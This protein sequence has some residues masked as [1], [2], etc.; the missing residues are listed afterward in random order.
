MGD[1]PLLLGGDAQLGC[2]IVVET[3]PQQAEHLRRALARGAD[4]EN[5]IEAALVL[6]IRLDESGEGLRVRAARSGLLLLG[7]AAPLL[8]D[9]GMGR[10]GLAPILAAEAPPDPS[11]FFVKIGE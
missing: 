4:D 1:L 10:E 7:P 6:P 11:G 2:G 8:P 5:V 3:C 9:P